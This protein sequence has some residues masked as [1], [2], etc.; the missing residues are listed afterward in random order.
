MALAASQRNVEFEDGRLGIFRVEN[1]VRAMTIGADGGLLGA[2]GDGI[3]VDALLIRGDHLD[4]EAVLL[5]DELLAM[6]GTASRR[7]IRV[8]NTRLGIC[9]RQELVRAS[10]TTCACRRIGVARLYGFAVEA[11][12]VGSLLIGVAG[13]ARNLF[14]SD[15]VRGGFY[16][17]VAI[18]AGE[19]AAVNRSFELVGIDMKSFCL[20]VDVMG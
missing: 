8:R 11:F 14:W 6:A 2:V 9:G 1:V 10:M 18:H 7:N 17:G 13:C 4:A 20:A 12:F 16:V 5:H 15:L 19:H 3:S